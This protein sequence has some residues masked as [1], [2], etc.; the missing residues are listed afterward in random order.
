MRR[1][2]WRT[3]F[4]I[5]VCA[6]LGWGLLRWGGGL[7]D[8]ARGRS[9]P[10]P[11]IP[12]AILGDSNS[13]SY[14]DRLSFPVSSGERGGK[15]QARTFQWGEILTRLRGDEFDLGPWVRWGHSG[16]VLR[17]FDLLGLPVGRAPRK[18]DYLYNF[19]Y[20]AMGCNELT[21]GKFRQAPRLVA[22]MD[23]EP[24][25][26]RHGVVVVRSGLG[27]WSAHLAEQARDPQAPVLREVTER[28]TQRIRESV[29]LIHAAHPDTRI[30]VVGVSNEAADPLQFEHWRSARESNNIVLAL[31]R[32]NAAL[33]AVVEAEPK[34][35]F[36][37]DDAWV[38]AHWGARDADGK[39]AYRTLTIGGTLQVSNSMGDDPTHA[40][41]QDGH[42][43]LVYNALWAQS[44]VARLREGFGLP[45]TPIGDADVARFVLPLAEASLRA[46]G[47]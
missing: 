3:A 32:F 5:M 2:A 16:V 40:I 27:D 6:A 45:L 34:T 42:A 15:N 43:G 33:R 9:V 11:A 46:P 26:W 20:S 47:S 41:L 37:D 28:C 25:R 38:R 8:E 10:A 23:R 4:A 12:L 1:I 7:P 19:A 44:L 29:R 24:E 13:H 31:D 18:D 21:Q 22:L 36:F 30:V 14:Q 35:I 17:V 39:P